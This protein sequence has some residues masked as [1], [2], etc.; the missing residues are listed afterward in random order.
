MRSHVLISVLLVCCLYSTASGERPVQYGKSI[1]SLDGR[2]TATYFG[3]QLRIR[4]KLRDDCVASVS[5]F[6]VHALAWTQNSKTIVTVEHIAGGSEVV[7]INLERDG[8][9]R[10]EIDPPCGTYDHY[11]VVDLVVGDRAV[12]VRYKAGR[13]A[14][15]R[16]AYYLCSFDLDAETR[17][18]S[19]EEKREIT[20]REYK[21]L[22]QVDARSRVQ[23]RN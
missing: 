7:L 12:K 9:H 19:N 5:V 6:P 11:A 21:D 1:G 15:Q 22:K 16:S 23:A 13:R 20:L 4:D 10:S 17:G 18:V 3:S 8:W 2:F 14:D